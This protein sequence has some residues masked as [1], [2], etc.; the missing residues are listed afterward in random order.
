MKNVAALACAALLVSACATSSPEDTPRQR[1]EQ[2]FRSAFTHGNPELAARVMA[3]DEVQQLCTKYR[4]RPPK[5]VA[6]R[7]EKSQAA[8]IVYPASG[9]LT[10]D[11]REGEKIAQ[12]GYGFRFTDTNAKRPNGGTLDA[13]GLKR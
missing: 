2:T 4:N 6:E 3:Q 1:A 5:D 11:W 12:D 9:R 10:G 7:I 13:P 8:T